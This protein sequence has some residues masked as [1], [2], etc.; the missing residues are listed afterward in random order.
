MKTRSKRLKKALNKHQKRAIIIFCFVIIGGLF[1]FVSRAAT[2]KVSFEAEA[3]TRTGRVDRIDSIGASG[4]QAARF[5]EISCGTISDKLVPS[6]GAW[7]GAWSNGGEHGV[8]SG[9]RA[10]IEEHESRIGRQ[11]NFVHYYH[12]QGAT[13][14]NDEKYFINR[15]NTYLLMNWKPAGTWGPAGGGNATVNADIDKTANSIKSVAP[16]KIM[17]VVFHEPENDVT[18][19]GAPGCTSGGYSSGAN[20]G[21]AAEY[22][23]MW[24]NVRNRFD[25][26]GV[27]NVVWAM[28]YMGFVSHDCMIKDLWPGNNLVDWVLFDPYPGGNENWDTGFG[29]F[30]KFLNNNS[31][32]AH[33]F[34]SKPY[35]VGEWGS[36]HKTQDKVY[37]LYDDGKA[38][39]AANKHPNI[40]LYTIFDAVGIDDSR[41]S[42]ND[43][44]QP[45]SVEQQH[46]N[47]FVSAPQLYQQRY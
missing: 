7:L 39:L 43:A 14:S 18:A 27:T 19:G 29:R 4:S 13:L 40:K 1:V 34:S 45:D 3:G 5:S 24:Q 44:S 37:K 41:V 21:T 11:V 8:G 20:K 47:S 12:G 17:L 36:W 15:P 32:V 10:S 2:V 35:G 33:A 31:D 30:Y 16:K 42:H 46:Y 28:N 6:C 9:L 38:A 26:L 25:A 23:A 22:R